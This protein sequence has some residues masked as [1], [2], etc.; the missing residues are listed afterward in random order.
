M[1]T[2]TVEEIKQMLR[3]AGA[4][5]VDQVLSIRFDKPG[6]RTPGVDE[7][8]KNQVFSVD[9]A[10]GTVLIV[11]DSYGHLLEVEIT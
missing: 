8:F 7:E 6:Y 5:Y 1:A 11:F 3:Q 4:E 9:C 10:Y 2:I